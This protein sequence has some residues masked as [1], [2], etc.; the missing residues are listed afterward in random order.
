M[1]TY[2]DIKGDGGSNVLGQI[3]E[4]HAAIE[5]RLSFVSRKIAICSGKGGVGKSTL[6]MALARSLA[7]QGLLVSLLDLDFNGPSLAHLAGLEDVVFVPGPY[8]LCPPTTEDGIAVL[9]FGSFL[10]PGATLDFASAAQGD[11][12][13]WRATKEFAVLADLLAK[14]DWGKRDI[15]LLDL[16][17]GADRTFQFA[18]FFGPSLEMILVST[19]SP[20][21]AGVVKRSLTALK[22]TPNKVLGYVENMAGYYCHDCLA[23]KLLFPEED[24]PALDVCKLGSV[25]FDSAL[26]SSPRGGRSPSLSAIED[27]ADLITNNQ[28]EGNEISVRAL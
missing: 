12:Q 16:P 2:S 1:K 20:L 3:S 13:T 18:E 22:R 11:T 5:Q 19:P 4:L 27:I 23:V 24:L 15:L 17:P 9:S 7:S 26:L 14:T 25:P 21:A 28:R 8:G 6:T 10:E